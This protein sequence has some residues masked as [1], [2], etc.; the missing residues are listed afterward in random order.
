MS[1]T[2]ATT[3]THLWLREETKPMEHRAALSPEV[4]KKL[5]AT[6]NFEIT[7]EESK[8]RIFADAEYTAVG[9]RL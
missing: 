4:C 3:T 7:V 5:L 9:C 8:E 1:G 6:G 2:T